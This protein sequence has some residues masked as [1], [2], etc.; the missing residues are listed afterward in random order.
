[1]VAFDNGRARR[2]HDAAQDDDA[3]NTIEQHPV[4]IGARDGEIAE[5]HRD[6]EDIVHR[7]AFFDDKARQVFKPGLRT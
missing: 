7:Q 5:D 4:L 3:E 6:D 2:N 1:M